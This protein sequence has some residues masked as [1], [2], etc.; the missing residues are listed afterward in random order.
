MGLAGL[1]LGLLWRVR[2]GGADFVETM[3]TLFKDTIQ[4]VG[5][6]KPK[7][8]TVSQAGADMARSVERLGGTAN[9]VRSTEAQALASSG[10]EADESAVKLE[11]AR[12]QIEI[13]RTEAAMAMLRSVAREGSIDQRL[14]AE[15]LLAQLGAT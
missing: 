4:L 15:K 3:S 14:A 11:V 13:G 6:S 10:T 7:V 1:V 9:L 2:R 8:I 12:T 5:K